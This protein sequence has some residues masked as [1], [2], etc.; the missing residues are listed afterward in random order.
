MP[1]GRGDRRIEDLDDAGD[2]EDG[3]DFVRL[4]MV[5]GFFL[6]SPR[7]HPALAIVPAL[8]A[9][10]LTVCLAA[11][12]PRTYTADM[13]VVTHHNGVLVEHDG[14]P[15]LPEPTA[16]VSDEILKRDSLEALIKQL[17]L[18]ARWD[19]MRS[20]VLRLKDKVVGLMRDESDKKAR[21]LVAILEKSI[22][23]A[24]EQNA[25]TLS[26]DWPNPQVAYEILNSSYNNFLEAR[27]DS[28]VNVYS[29]RLRVLELRAQIAAHDVDT[30]IENLVQREQ[31]R[32]GATPEPAAPAEAPPTAQ[33]QST[34]PAP[35][36]VI[37]R[38][39]PPPGSPSANDETARA[40]EDVR[41][42]IRAGE[43]ERRRRAAEADAQ[44]ADSLAALGPLHPTVLALK[45]KGEAVREPSP[46]LEALRAREKELVAKLAADIPAAATPQGSPG[47]LVHAPT[48]AA[49]PGVPSE[50]REMLLNRDDPPTAYARTK[51]Q[52]TSQQYNDI[53]GRLQLAKIER[54][55]AQASLRES[56]TVVRPSEV[57]VK[58]TKPNAVIIVAVGLIV[59]LLLGFAIPGV[60][61]LSAG[62]FIE[63]WQVEADL[64]MPVL[65]MLPPGEVRPATQD[66]GSG[67]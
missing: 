38:P 64:E 50:L 13:R 63:P 24:I 36:R 33:A 21:A 17:D 25:I 3:I 62:R 2:S 65:G 39:P 58:P 32:R 67:P 26:V 66:L 34:E 27:V 5:L 15:P 49:V 48:P 16:G 35:A 59:A 53:L 29:E 18:V 9:I 47:V 54:D 31:E 14:I 10:G 11:W 42:Q 45:R 60:R 41:A 44:L 7:R 30:A 12:W 51:L 8:F 43:D 20:P 52:A 4:R 28:E 55:V 19:A 1:M 22:K 56:Y 6:R 57:P 40:L 46:Q 61:D 23:V 37:A